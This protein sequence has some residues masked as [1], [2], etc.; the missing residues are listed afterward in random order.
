M[1]NIPLCTK[2]M[3]FLAM[4]NP[5]WYAAGEAM[6]WL[7]VRPG[8]EADGSDDVIGW[9]PPPAAEAPD[10]WGGERGPLGPGLEWVEPESDAVRFVKIG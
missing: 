7:R 3:G 10:C 4:E 2:T 6:L 8:P 9:A 5:P 1:H